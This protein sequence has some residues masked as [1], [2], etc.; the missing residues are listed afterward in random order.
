MITGSTV[1][2]R[3]DAHKSKVRCSAV[4]KDAQNR[5]PQEAYKLQKPGCAD[6]STQPP[7][8]RLVSKPLASRG[9]EV[10]VYRH[11][12]HASSHDQVDRLRCHLDATCHGG[13]AHPLV[14]VV[15]D[16]VVLAHED[17]AHDPQGAARR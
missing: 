15:E 2:L 16:A 14:A 3:M 6:T 5:R 12:S 13:D 10:E 17:V 1:K 8:I 4:T 7:N 11:R 9:P